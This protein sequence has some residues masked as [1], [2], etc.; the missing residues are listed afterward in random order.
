MGELGYIAVDMVSVFHK[1]TM[2][3]FPLILEEIDGLWELVLGEH[4][5]MEFVKFEYVLREFLPKLEDHI[6]VINFIQERATYQKQLQ[7]VF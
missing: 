3:I 5:M 2:K 4:I 7:S 1:Y 6:K